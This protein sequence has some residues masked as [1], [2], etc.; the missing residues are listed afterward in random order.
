MEQEKLDCHIF[1][2]HEVAKIFLED[3]NN[4][5]E[6]SSVTNSS[7]TANTSSISVTN[8][9]ESVTNSFPSSTDSTGSSSISFTQDSILH[10]DSNSTPT[11]DKNY[12]GFVLAICKYQKK[13]KSKWIKYHSCFS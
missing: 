11:D 13:R 5:W 12:T 4:L 7:A 2:R 9:S 8:S 10:L 1:S 3:F 6:E